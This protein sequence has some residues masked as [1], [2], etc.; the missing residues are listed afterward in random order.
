MDL[1]LEDCT[2]GGYFAA[3][4]RPKVVVRMRNCVDGMGMISCI[5]S[6]DRTGQSKVQENLV[7][8]V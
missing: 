5:E 1:V 3:A 8:E 6:Y 4:G 7:V 2:K